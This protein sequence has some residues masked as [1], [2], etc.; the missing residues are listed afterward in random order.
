MS[1]PSSG[2]EASGRLVVVSNRLGDPSR[3][4][5]GGL[6]V[7][8]NGA[9]NELG[10]IWMGWSGETTTGE[11][12]DADRLDVRDTG[13]VLI[14]GVDIDAADYAGYYEGYANSVLWPLFHGR[15]DLMEPQPDY[16][17]AYGRVN[18]LF[19]RQLAGLIRPD[20]TVWVHDYHLIP[21]AEE[22]RK[23]GVE[24]RIGFFLHIP[25]PPSQ[26][27]A[28][29][30]GHEALIRNLFHYDL[31]GFQTHADVVNFSL[32]TQ[33]VLAMEP[34]EAGPLR[35]FG[36]EMHARAFPIGI[37]VDQFRDLLLTEE[38]R[39]LVSR[40]GSTTAGRN[41]IAGVDRL[42]YSKGL[43]ER[44][45]VFERLLEKYPEN[46]RQTTL[47]QIAS[48]TR[49]NVEA[50]ADIRDELDRL[51]GHVNG[52]FATID[53]TPIRYIFRHV[54]RARL[55]GLYSISKVGLVTPLR[56]GMNLV[57]KEFVAVQD[58]DDP[59]VLV[60]SE[61]AGAAEEMTEALLVNP[62]DIESTA[63]TVQRALTM[64][65][66]ERRERHRVL[67][68]RVERGDVVAWSR[69]FLDAL[70]AI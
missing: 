61:F 44:L 17:A 56:D 45:R 55:A 37:D 64:P 28:A 10:G 13:K 5:K 63:D 14:A 20:D 60:L 68:E 11:V 67:R 33:R 22:L 46:D 42:D 50:Y 69:A 54:E 6:A 31:V 19:A 40:V 47:V 2:R 18:A 12:S 49:E 57:A 24:N 70:A 16:L 3:P 52:R 39:E 36:R 26:L 25:M 62:H 9:L 53:W 27:M 8:L 35:A 29:V 23:L 43:P 21:L 65:L 51:S 48:P 4:A 41:L 58:D 30:P 38:S 15:Q 1:G 59:G 66:A 34:Q 7:A 32:Y